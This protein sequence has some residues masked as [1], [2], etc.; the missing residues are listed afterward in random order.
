LFE[1][2]K[3]FNHREVDRSVMN[4]VGVFHVSIHEPAELAD[5][6]IKEVEAYKVARRTERDP[7]REHCCHDVADV[8]PV[9]AV[10]RVAG[11]KGRRHFCQDQISA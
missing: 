8:L 4:A 5:R 6:P 9:L 11:T 3:R 2:Q 7:V 1:A 10:H